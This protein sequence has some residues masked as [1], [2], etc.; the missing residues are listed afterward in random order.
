MPDRGGPLG[1][2]VLPGRGKK[3]AKA[4][5]LAGAQLELDQAA[6]GVRQAID[7]L[8]TLALEGVDKMPNMRYRS[9]VMG[10]TREFRMAVARYEK[11]VAA[12][13][14]LAFIDSMG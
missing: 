13:A 5:T 14:Q 3:G 11:A 9:E 7:R 8:S 12:Y 4:D 6:V 10:E 1:F 2:G